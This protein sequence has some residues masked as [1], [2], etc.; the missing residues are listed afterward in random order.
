MPAPV[1]QL[2]EQAMQSAR[3]GRDS[4]AE[5]LWRKVLDK[6]P[7][8]TQALRNLGAR[9]LQQRDTDEALSMLEAARLTAPTDLFVLLMLADARALAG[10]TD[11]E[12]EAIRWALA[13]DPYYVPALLKKGRWYECQG[14][15]RSACDAYSEAAKNAGPESQWTGQLRSEL[16]AGRTYIGRHSRDLHQLLS[17]EIAEYI[18]AVDRASV[19]RW[20]EAVS[21]HAGRSVPYDSVSESLHIPRLP[22]IPF[23]GRSEFS[24]LADLE[25]NV[26]RI[27]DELAAVLQQGEFRPYIAYRPDEPVRQWQELNHSTRWSAFHLWRNGEPVAEN[28]ERCPET[29]KLLENVELCELSGISPNVFFSALAPKTHIPPHHGETNARVSAHLPLIVPEDCRLR[30]GFEERCWREGETLVF[31]DTI[32]HEAFNDS[33][34][35]RVVM[36]FDL[37]NPL[38]GEADRQ[39]AKI[40]AEARRNFGN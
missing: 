9:A 26:G 1:T 13:V 2:V 6:E 18:R 37:W 35:L 40:L 32:E 29:A 5:K 10:D 7:R 19:E 20:R 21:L 23:F 17:A 25:T 27:H 38:L 8:H 14:K 16:D 15:A 12:L 36:V 3:S 11:G 4:E 31:D 39:V 24:F 30:V 22:A 28:I 33:N 34:A